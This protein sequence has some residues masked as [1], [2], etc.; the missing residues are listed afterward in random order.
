MGM[1]STHDVTSTWESGEQFR[2]A[3][4]ASPTGMIMVDQR[5]TIVLI[6]AQVERLFGYSRTE[7]VG[8]P[9]EILV[10]TRFR[11]RH[12]GFRNSFFGDVKARPMGAG[13]DLFGVRKD[14]SELPIEIGLNPLETP[15]GTFVL[16]SIVDITERRRAMEQIRASLAEKETLLREI[17]HRVKN[18]LQVISS[19]LNLQAEH[20]PDVRE[21]LEQSQAR[22]QSI[23]LVHE[24]LYRSQSVSHVDFDD[25]VHDLIGNTFHAQQA[26]SRNISYQVDVSAV[27]LPIDIAVPCGLIISELVTNALKHAFV[28]RDA[29]HIDIRLSQQDGMCEL[30]IA[31]N[32]IGLPAEIADNT[33][34]IRT[35]GLEL[36]MTFGQQLHADIHIARDNG[37][38]FTLRFKGG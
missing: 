6:N 9:I 8:Q 31:D 19:L 13:R 11:A 20:S 7:I 27:R 28:E 33:R 24:G 35:L 14:G 18:N 37:T 10:P 5:G 23:A 26:H 34:E 32:G 2:L 3:I 1:D 29:G 12:P 17:H 38:T 16:S 15:Q 30:R 36:V 25:Y 4:E 22:I 21:A